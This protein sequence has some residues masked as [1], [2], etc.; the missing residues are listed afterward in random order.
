MPEM[1][2][3]VVAWVVERQRAL[4]EQIERL[5]AE[6]KK[7]DAF[8]EVWGEFPGAGA[9]VTFSQGSSV[10]AT[11]VEVAEQATFDALATAAGGSVGQKE[12]ERLAREIILKRGAP[13]TGP[14]LL[15][16]FRERGRPI[17][18]MN[19]LKNV[20][21]KLSRA[22]DKFINKRGLGYWPSDVPNP[23]IG[24]APTAKVTAEQVKGSVS[25]AA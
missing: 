1:G 5:Q 9:A 7:Y 4:R 18:G 11:A 21:T 10:R 6:I 2:P 13:L 8:L 20:G 25:D 22:G 23:S 24:Y 16:A 17:G 19:E 15:E 12:F 14:Q 3:D